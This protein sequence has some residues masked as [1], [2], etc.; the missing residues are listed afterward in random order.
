[1][2]DTPWVRREEI[3]QGFTS[4]V[5]AYRATTAQ[6][7]ANDAATKVQFNAENYDGLGEFDP[8]T[9]YRFTATASG[10][11]LVTATVL[12]DA[13]GVVAAKRHA[14][15][16]YQ[17]G[18]EVAAE[19]RHTGLVDYVSSSVTAILYVA[20]G[21]YLEIY[22]YQNFGGN[23]DIMILSRRSRVQIHRLS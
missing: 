20:A 8:T 23:A 5:S 22:A 2:R 12:W 21:S 3:P 18:A 19:H 14:L 13:A 11:Y 4:R 17:D 1:M 9:N 16:V 6:T 7:I 10:Y 15:Y